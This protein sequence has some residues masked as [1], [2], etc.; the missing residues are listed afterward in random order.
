M[1][2]NSVFPWVICSLHTNFDSPKEKQKTF[3][4]SCNKTTLNNNHEGQQ[5]ATIFAPQTTL[6]IINKRIKAKTACD[7]LPY[8]QKITIN[9]CIKIPS[10]RNFLKNFEKNQ[11]F[12]QKVKHRIKSFWKKSLP[13]KKFCNMLQ[14][15]ISNSKVN[16][17]SSTSSTWVILNV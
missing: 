9:F 5:T 16:P 1:L 10:H 11:N 15:K 6:L 7:P 12:Y 17:T 13:S 14:Y 2:K 8:G 3:Y 4:K